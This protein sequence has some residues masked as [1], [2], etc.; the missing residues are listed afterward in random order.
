MLSS[1]RCSVSTTEVYRPVESAQIRSGKFR[2]A[3]NSHRLLGS[4]DR[5]AT[6]DDNAAMESF[7][8]LLQK[9][10]LNRRCWAT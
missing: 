6:C 4:I 10:L 7:F 8:S 1:V 3:L 5:V 9:N 2:R